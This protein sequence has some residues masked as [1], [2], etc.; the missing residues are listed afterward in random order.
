MLAIAIAIGTLIA[1]KG[2]LPLEKLFYACLTAIFLEAATFSLNDYFDLEI[3]K[4]NRRMDRPLVRG[5]LKPEHAL[6]LFYLLF[7][8]GLLFAFFVNNVC[9]IIALVTGVLAIIYD[10]K[11]K[12][13]KLIGNFYIAYTMAIPFIFGGTVISTSIPFIVYIIAAIAFLSGSG[14]EVMKDVMDYRGD[15]KKGVKSLPVYIGV[16][17]SILVTNI[18]YL[19]AIIVSMLPFILPIDKSFYF[20]YLYLS[21]VLIADLLFAYVV[22]DLFVKKEQNIKLHRKVTLLAMFIG[23][24]AFLIG[25]F[26]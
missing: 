15:K 16:K 26:M 6:I 24:V 19:F 4:E 1:G 9:F 12:K 7:P 25:A 8:I 22:T 17:N 18:F 11:M 13:V 21:V 23:L 14:R 3:D 2:F 20:D 5:D 10:M